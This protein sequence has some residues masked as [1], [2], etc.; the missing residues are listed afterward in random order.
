M[1]PHANRARG[2]LNRPLAVCSLSAGLRRLSTPIAGTPSHR[3]HNHTIDFDT[4]VNEIGA[5][6]TH[7]GGRW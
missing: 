1:V 2:S 7:L 5:S 6:G 4:R 3:S